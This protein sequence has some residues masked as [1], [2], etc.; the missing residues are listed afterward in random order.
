MNVLRWSASLLA[1]AAVWALA[2]QAHAQGVTVQGQVQYQPYGQQPQQGYG[3]P[4]PGYG[5][6]Q[7]QPYAQPYQQQP[8]YAP[9]YQQQ[10]PRVRYVER[11]ATIKGL[12][13]PGIII[14]GV[15]YALTAAFSQFSFDTD[16]A[17]WGYVP[18]IGP[19]VSLGFANTEDEVTGAVLG[20]VAQAAGL[21]MFILGLS[22]RRTVRV[23]QYALDGDDP[24]SPQLAFDALP[25]PG[26][27]QLGL[28]LS[29]F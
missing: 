25:A 15:S 20:G 13:I 12:W 17:T 19:W 10:Q 4:P 22:L 7:Q 5:Q 18:L 27:A 28:T 21:T 6:Q 26:G 11:S 14:F 9:T 29:H 23:A 16:Y 3:N 8:Q 1:L 2:P 24:R